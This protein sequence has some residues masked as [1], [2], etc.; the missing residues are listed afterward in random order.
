MLRPY[1]VRFTE[2]FLA[3]LVKQDVNTFPFGDESFTFGVR[4][5]A[6]VA[7]DHPEII[8][9]FQLGYL[10][11]ESPVSGEFSHFLSV[12]NYLNGQRISLE[13]PRL[14]TARVKIADRVADLIL[15][16]TPHQLRKLASQTASC[17]KETLA[18][19][20]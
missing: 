2:A 13:N 14:I 16:K 1:E 6:E 17:F 5:M 10:F 15:E 4:K 12:L 18:A 11:N 3:E 20:A 8:N 7:R 19:G 9:E